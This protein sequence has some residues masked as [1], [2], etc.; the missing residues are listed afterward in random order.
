MKSL[1]LSD[2]FNVVQGMQLAGIK[3]LYTKD[4]DELKDIF[5][6]N[7]KDEDIGIIIVTENVSNILSDSILNHREK[8]RLPLI[9]TIPGIGGLEDKNFIMKYIKESLGVKIE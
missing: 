8:G 5:N 9:V 3:S 2:E 1:V 4:K 7:I 6:K